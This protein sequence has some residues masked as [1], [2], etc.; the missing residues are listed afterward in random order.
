[1]VMC[2]VKGCDNKSKVYSIIMFHRIPTKNKQRKNQWLAALNID[3]KTPVESIKKWRV[4][5]DH[6]GPD[7][8]LENMDSVT[9]TTVRRLKDTVIP[10]IFKAQTGP[11]GSSPMAVELGDVLQDL[12]EH[13]DSF[14]LFAFVP[15]SIPQK[16]RPAKELPAEFKVPLPLQLTSPAQTVTCTK[17]FAAL[18][19]TW[20]QLDTASSPS[21]MA[22]CSPR[23]SLIFDE[24]NTS[25]VMDISS[26]SA[27][28]ISMCSEP[29]ADPADASFAPITSSSTSTTGSTGGWKERK[30]IVNESKLMELFQKCS[31]C[32]AVMS[33]ADRTIRTIGSRI[34]VSWKC[35]NGHT[36]HW[37]SCPNTRGMPENNLLAAP[38]TLFTGPT[39]D[40]K[41][42][43]CNIQTSY[44]IP[45]IKAAYKKQEDI[46]KAQLICQTR[47]GEGVQLCGDGRSDSPGHSCSYTTYSF[48]DDSS[49]K[50]SQATSS[51]AMEPTGFRKGLETLLD[52]GIDIKVV[53][54]DRHP[55]D[56]KLIREEYP[57]IIHQFDPCHLAKEIKK[58]LVSASSRRNCSDLAPWV[59]SVSN[60]MWW[61]CCSSKGDAMELH[62]RWKSILHHILGVHH[63]EENG[64]EYKC[65][66]KE[67]TRDQQRMKKWLSVDSP[68]Y[69]ALVEIVMDKCLLKDLEQMMLFKHSL[70]IGL[71]D[72]SKR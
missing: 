16:S 52:E 6:F 57:N 41:T 20:T 18:A 4:C 72:P 59:K 10:T 15:Q 27:L 37:E 45:V 35:I 50:V 21:V 62:R 31:T 63:W 26:T 34:T 58:K 60:H 7:D 40:K 11:S 55:S 53:T 71:P 46:I 22:V 67:L 24:T 48:M 66:H 39:F 29:D 54:M 8:Y 47:D 12:P 13:E 14:S 68:A 49:N 65:Y 56:R 3:L 38:A 70:S 61:S 44:L 19:P 17:P 51:I 42:T 2:V 5:S 69:K 25:S 1:M 33:E 28:D 36:G 30:W 9:R 23:K 64:I 43:H 32:L